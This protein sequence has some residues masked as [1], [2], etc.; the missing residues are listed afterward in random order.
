MEKLSLIHPHCNPQA[1][2]SPVQ[3]VPIFLCHTPRASSLGAGFTARRGCVETPAL[4]LLLAASLEQG[5]RA[6]HSS[7]LGSPYSSHLDHPNPFCLFDLHALSRAIP[8]LLSILC[9]Q[10]PFLWLS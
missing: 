9:L 8:Q 6:E 1:R 2:S 3:A 4:D 5:R 7:G 10:P